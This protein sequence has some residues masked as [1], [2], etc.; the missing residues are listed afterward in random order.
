MNGK[1]KTILRRCY[2]LFAVAFWIGLWWLIAALYARPLILPTPLG[3]LRA[4][5]ALMRTG[6]F[7]LTILLSL[8]R[9]LFGIALAL[10]LGAL[11]AI[12][13]CKSPLCHH[14]FSPLL[15]LFKAMP[16]ASIIFLL[17]LWVGNMWVPFAIAVMMAL[18]IVWGNVREGLLQTDGKLLEMAK[19]F[20][21]PRASVMKKIYLP[22]LK[23]YLLAAVRSAVSLAW[24]AGV[25]AEVLC[26][27]ERSIGRAIFE[28]KLYLLTDELFA[29][30]FVV[31][32]IS[33]LIEAGALAL[34]SRAKGAENGRE[35]E[36]EEAEHDRVA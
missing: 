26:V 33:M 17:L 13:T 6:E 1:T 11:L 32:I 31:I 2:P 28:G 29:W 16:V 34:L 24:K 20:G 18:P 10:A 36:G 15:T 23:P 19:V 22:S 12:L 7:Y 9:I 14:L 21:V 4:L 27:P 8:S 25:A 3:M 30:T 35:T 5:G